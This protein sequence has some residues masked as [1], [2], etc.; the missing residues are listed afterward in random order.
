MRFVRWA[1]FAAFVVVLANVTAIGT[2][3]A[4]A[5]PRAA[6]T[7][8][9]DVGK[10]PPAVTKSNF[11]VD[12]ATQAYLNQVSGKARARSDAYFEGGY[13]LLLVDTLYTLAVAAL[14]LWLK[15][16]AR[17]RN[18]AQAITRSRFWQVPV[19]VAQFIVVTA[20]LSFPLTLYEDFFREH[21]Y[22]LSNQTFLEW[23]GD[24]GKSFGVQ[25]VAMVV[26]LT[27]IYAVIRGSRRLWWMW[28]TLVTVAFMAFA[29][30]IAPVFISPLFN[31]YTPM[32]PGALKSQIVSIAKANGI[33]ADDIYVFDASKQSKRI[34]AN[35]SGFAGTTRISLNDNLLNRSSPR[36]ILA[37]MGH[38]MGHY[39]LDHSVILLTW[40]GLLILTGFAFVNWGFGILTGIFGGNWD[41]RTIDDPAGL[42]VIMALFSVFMLI[43]TPVKNTIIRTAETQADI[44]GLNAARQPDGFATVTLK[45]A[46]YRKL[47]PGKW[48][49]IIFYDHPSG[50]QPHPYGDAMEGRAS[51]RRRYRSG[52]RVATMKGFELSI[53]REGAPLHAAAH[54]HHPWPDV[55]RAAQELC[56]DDA[57]RLLDKKWDHIFGEVM[58]KAAGHIARQLGLPDPATIAFGPNTHSFV[59]R[60]LSCFPPGK[61]IRILT[62]G[63]EFMSFTRQTARF[64][65][66]GMAEVTRVPTEPFDTFETRFAAEAKKG[67]HDLV[68][69]SQA[70]FDS[71]F[72]GAR[73]QRDGRCGAG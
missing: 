3:Q 5:T 58:P 38:E 1:A 55:S 65:E 46:E 73:P 72:R 36:E 30:L 6:P 20:V 19:Y 69:F 37:V 31:T 40:L 28:G 34:S 41:V 17:M 27:I 47:S 10:L 71:G 51:A 57:A 25:L 32:K 49:E 35:V 15:I 52:A 54:S 21:A 43:A 61:P 50:P 59:L 24:F 8:S 4:Q 29:M 44:F 33:P 11:D 62:T 42:P 45:L 64:E 2:A 53:G 68:F 23:F 12:K 56:W 67:G 18:M 26:L 13:W 7:A 9:V 16:S 60:L 48:E 66:D 39:V 14:L 70:Y 22:G 63:S